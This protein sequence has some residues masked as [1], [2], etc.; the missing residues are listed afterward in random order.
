MIN[1]SRTPDGVRFS[2][3]S[4]QGKTLIREIIQQR[5]P[6]WSNGPRDSQVERR[7]EDDITGIRLAAWLGVRKAS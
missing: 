7:L 4:P 3:L 5:L 1:T 6:Q 2:W